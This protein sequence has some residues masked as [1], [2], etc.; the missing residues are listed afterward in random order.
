MH[1]FYIYRFLRRNFKSAP[2]KIQELAYCSM[3]CP[4]VEYAASVW[5]SPWLLK[6][7]QKLEALQRRSARF[8][9]RNYQQTASVTNMISWDSLESRR[10]R[11]R[12]YMLYKIISSTPLSRMEPSHHNLRNY[13]HQQITPLYCR[14]DVYILILPPD[15]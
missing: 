1:A 15:N 11:F 2:L 9:L 12:I 14:I 7:I 5:S 13:H 4:Q 10:K 3:V 6:D 8:V